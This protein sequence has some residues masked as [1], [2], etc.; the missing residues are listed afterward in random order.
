MLIYKKFDSL[1]RFGVELETGK[2][3]SKVKTAFQVERFS[4]RK[5]VVSSYA[6]TGDSNYWHVKSDA[7]C[8]G[9]E[10]ASFVCLG[11]QDLDHVA[12]I[13]E[14]LSLAGAKVNDRCGLHIHAEAIDLTPHQVSILLSYWLKMEDTL[15]LCLPRRRLTSVHCKN[16]CCLGIGEKNTK[17]GLFSKDYFYNWT[18]QDVW[19][20]FKPEDLTTTTNNSDRRFNLNLVNY[21]KALVKGNNYRKTLELRWPEGTLD[22]LDIKC[23]VRLFLNFIDNCKDK[24]MPI[25][26]NPVGLFETLIYLGLGHDKNNFYI[27]DEALYETKI[28]FLNRIIKFSKEP[29]FK[30]RVYPNSFVAQNIIKEAEKILDYISVSN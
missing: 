18:P 24:E 22:P 10:I 13:A 28:W 7:S 11:S 20:A 2:H 30:E 9:P 12:F 15:S 3:L 1:R 21:V 25:S 27:F 8:G 6:H 5:V 16:L 14:K 4:K 23:W 19:F 29:D 17:K 26:L